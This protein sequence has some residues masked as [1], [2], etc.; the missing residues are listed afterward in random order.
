MSVAL[1]PMHGAQRL[2][3]LCTPGQWP[4]ADSSPR[5]VGT[6]WTPGR[7]PGQTGAGLSLQAGEGEPATDS[8]LHMQ[9]GEHGCLEWARRVPSLLAPASPLPAGAARSSLW[10]AASPPTQGC[11]GWN[12]PCAHF[13]VG[14][15]C[16]AP[17]ISEAAEAAAFTT[18]LD[19]VR[20]AGSS[21][22]SV[23]VVQAHVELGLPV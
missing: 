18:R 22:A 16:S 6:L 20:L 9:V 7:G 13:P 14:S 1:G 8:R 5:D 2:G 21:R 4:H 19:S 17:L 11:I 3:E 10:G 12:F 15:R 23:G